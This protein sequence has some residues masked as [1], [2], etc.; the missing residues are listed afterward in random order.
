M[1]LT[2]TET[3]ILK[4]VFRQGI[5]FFL[6]LVFIFSLWALAKNYH[7]TT[8]CEFGI[9]E[10]IQLGLL[11]LSAGVFVLNACL[12]RKETPLFLFLAGLCL[13]GLCR[14][15]DS[16][17]DFYLPVISWKFGFLFPGAALINLARHR[18]EIRQSFFYFLKTSAFHMMWASLLIGIALAQALGHRSF[19]ADVLGGEA[20]ARAIRRILEEGTEVVAY[21]LLALSGIECYFNFRHKK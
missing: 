4:Q 21:F 2:A 18:K 6:T 12:F 11:F 3:K 16:L 15:L 8:F 1:F 19:I 13:L 20:D 10:N 9:V 5:Y 7:K 14:E 17:F